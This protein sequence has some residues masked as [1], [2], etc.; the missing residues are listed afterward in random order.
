MP[1]L[2]VHITDLCNSKCSFCV[3][4]SPFY[5][6]DSVSFDHIL[7]FIRE[8]AGSGFTEVNIHGGEP[9][10]HPRFHEILSA[11][12]MLGYPE[13]HLQTNGIRLEDADLVVEYVRL[14]V[15]LFIISLHGSTE[16]MHDDQTG[17]RGFYKTLAGIRNAKSLGAAVRTNTVVSS[18]N[19]EHLRDISLLACESGADHINISNIHPVESANLSFDKVVPTSGTLIRNVDDAV[20][21]ALDAN[22][23]VTLEGFPYCWLPRHKHLH[24]NENQRRIKML[25]R[26]AIIDNYDTFMN[27]ACRVLGPP[28]ATCSAAKRCGGVYPEYVARR[29]WGEFNEI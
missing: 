6:A 15:R 7:N 22:R 25:M 17:S 24:L 3:V 29:G 19:V 26:G 9:T 10:I 20:T 16:R 2:S 21:V 23:K 27:D 1:G 4:G 28:C 12:K 14:G 8:N 13:V 11:I 5:R 18:R